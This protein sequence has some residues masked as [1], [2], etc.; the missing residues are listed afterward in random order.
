MKHRKP[1]F[2][3]CC[4]YGMNLEQNQ[5]EETKGNYVR[6]ITNYRKCGFKI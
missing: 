5:T 4:G 6:V 1:Y 3:K 2:P